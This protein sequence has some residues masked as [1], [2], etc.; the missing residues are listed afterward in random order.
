MHRNGYV[1][2]QGLHLW[3]MG[4]TFPLVWGEVANGTLGSTQHCPSY[5]ILTTCIAE[6][7]PLLHSDPEAI[8][9]SKH[10]TFFSMKWNGFC[11]E[12]CL[13]RSGDWPT[14]VPIRTREKTNAVLVFSLVLMGT[15]VGQIGKHLCYS[16]SDITYY[17]PLGDWWS[18][19]KYSYHTE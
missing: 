14:F 16:I 3:R 8:I 2:A 5:V 1:N 17:A 7:I 6:C 4:D 15:N 18:C 9:W 19:G 12:K 10:R 13:S 11:W